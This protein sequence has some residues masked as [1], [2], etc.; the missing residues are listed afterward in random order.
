MKLQKHGINTSLVEITN[1]STHGF[2]ILIRG[3]EYFLDYEHYP[4]FRQAT[5]D[6]LLRVRLLHRSHLYW[7]DLD[8]D[9]EVESIGHPDQYPLVYR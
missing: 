8:V 6:Q 7:P 4:W 5:I 3:T 2:W 9:L 1:V